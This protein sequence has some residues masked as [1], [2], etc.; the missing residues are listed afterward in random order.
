[1]VKLVT[2]H[3]LVPSLP[4]LFPLQLEALPDF[5]HLQQWVTLP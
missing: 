1:M 4:M 3:N 2:Q 5:L